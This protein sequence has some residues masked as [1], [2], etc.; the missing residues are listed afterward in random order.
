MGWA[1]DKPLDNYFPNFPLRDDNK[2]GQYVQ[3]WSIP[4]TLHEYEIAD[5]TATA[6][7]LP[8]NPYYNAANPAKNQ[9][10]ISQ[11][12]RVLRYKAPDWDIT[13][14]A[15]AGYYY[16]AD[17]LE[18][19]KWGVEK[20][21][22]D[23]HESIPA[24]NDNEGCPEF[25]D[26]GLNFIIQDPELA[27]RISLQEFLQDLTFEQITNRKG[28]NKPSW[29]DP[30]N[31]ATGDFSFSHTN[32]SLPAVMPLEFKVTYNSRHNYN[33]VLGAGWHH[34]FE[35]HLERTEGGVMH[36]ITPEGGRYVYTPSGNG[37][38]T[39][40]AGGFDTLRKQVDGTFLLETPQKLRYLFRQDGMLSSITDAN[41]N[42]IKLTYNGTILTKAETAGASLSFTYGS[43]GKLAV[44]TD[45]TGREVHYEVEELSHNLLS[46]QL[47]D[48]ATIRF[49]YDNKHQMTEID[50]PNHSSTLV[51]EYDNQ[52]RVVRRRDFNGHWGTVEYHPEE[53]YTLTT[54]PLGRIKRF[55]YNERMLQT[56]IHYP[57]GT[58]ERFEYDAND[59]MTARIDRNGSIWR[60]SYDTFGNVRQQTDPLGNVTDI[61]YNG[62]NQPEVITDA[63]GGRTVLGYDERGT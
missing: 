31:L 11:A 53:R 48:S 59:K 47:P 14:Q 29:W 15:I 5:I 1:Q 23:N 35:R 63:L 17:T 38:Y 46:I 28:H 22:A 16:K 7:R 34:T 33:G 56:A 50:D 51:N 27:G 25:I 49:R 30:I 10:G 20:I 21:A 43:G 60:Y 9:S 3:Q 36:L 8:S 40:P 13:W 52:G 41:G 54:D 24:C 42:Q 55:D 26:K 19:L 18:K 57:D 6:E 39:T 61:S 37:G 2:P 32:I 44:V 58:V 45:Q 12:I 62:F 4:Y